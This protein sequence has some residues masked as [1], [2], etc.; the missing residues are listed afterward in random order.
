MT[1]F[2]STGKII[3][4]I[5]SKLPLAKTELLYIISD[6]ASK[7]PITKR[8]KASGRSVK[9]MM[10]QPLE[11]SVS[12]SSALPIVP[13]RTATIA[14]IVILAL[15]LLY[16]FRGV[17][18]VAMVN[19]QPITHLQLIQELEK[20]G[21]QQ[22]LNGLITQTLILQEAKKENV[23]VSDKEIQNQVQQIT[24]SLTKQGQ[25]LDDLLTARGMTQQDLDEQIR[26]QKLVEKMA[27]KGITVSD[28]EINDYINAN[29]NQ[30]PTN[31]SDKQL[32]DYVKQQL[33]QQKLSER[34]QTWVANL[35]KNA[36]IVKFV[37][38]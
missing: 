10:K 29:K 20:Q 19:G 18:I 38:F 30:L 4:K 28:R 35:Q 32:H 16:Y 1:R 14:V 13:R 22:T 37:S 34:E 24:I 36:K 11:A 21:G 9:S 25:K 6:M 3:S 7:R 33:M 15:A 27:G 26:V 8:K 5:F 23:T 17:F 12:Q 2:P 31:M